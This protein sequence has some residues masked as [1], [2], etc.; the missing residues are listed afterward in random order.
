MSIP[1]PVHL[2]AL[3]AAPEHHRLLLENDQ[4]RVLEALIPPGERTAVHAHR[5]PA[6]QYVVSFSHF[7]RRDAAGQITLDSRSQPPL[8]AGTAIW[9]EPL[10]PHSA[11]NVGATDL[12]VIVV[13]IKSAV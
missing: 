4:V 12:R 6:V 5:W 7:V 1:T 3:V 13:E 11:E 2:D 10:L 9:S 8:A